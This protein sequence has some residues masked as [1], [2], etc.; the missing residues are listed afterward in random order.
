ME[1]AWEDPHGLVWRFAAPATT[2]DVLDVEVL[3]THDL[4][5]DVAC[6]RPIR[7]EAIAR[8]GGWLV[9]RTVDVDG[10]VDEAGDGWADWSH[11]ARFDALDGLLEIPH[12]LTYYRAI[13]AEVS[14][15][16][17]TCTQAG[18][19]FSLMLEGGCQC[20]LCTG[21]A[22]ESTPALERLC[23]SLQFSQH[24]HHMV[25]LWL[26]VR[27]EPVMDQPYWMHQLKSEWMAA[28]GRKHKT[29][30]AQRSEK[31]RVRERMKAMGML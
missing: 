10:L 9:A 2:R 3:V 18:Q 21:R 4:K 1:G 6:E 27:D 23:A 25:G 8:L 24:L 31:E 30:R 19:L 7:P 11:L 15:P 22:T 12:W 20:K 16:E 5:A 14:L 13:V 26:P 17:S 28:E 29:D